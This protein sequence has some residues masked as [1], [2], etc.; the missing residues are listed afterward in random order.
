[1]QERKLAGVWPVMLTPFTEE[2]KVDYPALASLIEW[3]L[4]QG[5]A[6]MFAVCQSS[7]M[8][9]LS[10]EERV[11]I[12]R[13]VNE[14][15]N[16]RVPVI[17]SG[18]IS[19]SM[20][21]QV[22]E[23]LAVAETGVE[24]VI[25]ITN[26]LAKEEESDTIWLENLKKLLAQIP[27]EIHLGF[28]E[29]PY[30][31]KRV[32]SPEL[33]RFCVES[34]RFY[35]LKDTCCDI[36][37]IRAKLEVCKDSQLKLYNAN[38][39]TLL[40]S[41]RLG[42]AGYSGVMANMQCSLYVRMCEDFDNPSYDMERLSRQLTMC[43]LIERQYYPVNAKYYLQL[44]GVLPAFH[45]R[46][47][48]ASGLNETWKAEMR[49]LRE[50]T[51][52]LRKEYRTEE[53]EQVG[54]NEMP[55]YVDEQQPNCD[56][57]HGQ[58]FPAKGVKCRQIV[59]ANCHYPELADGTD[60]TYKHA[61]D[62]AYFAGRFYV[63][64][65]CNPKEEHT[66]AGY[67]VLAS[68]VDGEIWDKFQIS[69]PMYPIRKTTVTDYKGLTHTFDGSQFAF[70]HQR[71]GFFRSS[72]NRMLVLGFYGWSPEKWMTNWDNYGIGRVVREL[73]PDGSLSAIYFIRP[74][75]QGGWSKN[76][77]NYPLY[78]ESKDE[79]FVE[80]CEELLASPLVV[81]QWAEEN[82]D[83][84]SLIQIKHPKRGTY[85]AFCSY[86]I[87]ENEVVG[88]WKHSFVA[89]SHD[90]GKNWSQVQKSPSLVMSGQKIWG[91]KTSDGRFALAYDPTLETEH[92][93][94]L[95]VTTSRDGIHFSKMRLVHGQV[96][97]IRNNG[98]WKDLGP[99]YMR[100][101]AEGI[102]CEEN[103][104]QD[105]DMYLTYSVNKE[106][107]WFAQIPV[108][109]EDESQREWKEFPALPLHRRNW[110]EYTPKWVSVQSIQRQGIDFPILEVK[111]REPMDYSVLERVL[112]PAKHRIL[113]MSLIPQK[114]QEGIYLEL[115]DAKAAVAVRLVFRNNGILY[116]RTVTEL[117]VIPYECER[118]IKINLDVDCRNF[119]YT[120]EIN[121]TPIC[122]SEGNMVKWKF[123]QA[124]NETSRFSI[125]TGSRK[126]SITLETI[127]DRLS[128]VPKAM[129][130]PLEEETAYA[131]VQV[132]TK[133]I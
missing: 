47:K 15:V 131:L 13:F 73:Y 12:A 104:P 44:E 77:L 18:H 21:E 92:R 14:T 23:I 60:S 124:V 87:D 98:F 31:Y 3:Y 84:D 66:G 5:V 25:L 117:N 70:M 88:L 52:L 122:N 22:R 123:M 109:I 79:A 37:Q 129:S 127:P 111:D 102:L 27:E 81:Q 108:P 97:R 59:R 51:R 71:M 54:E 100:G 75:W 6:G 10:L 33:L 78:Q 32:L 9:Y 105:L 19:D 94:P 106:D 16:G 41:L 64:Y 20:E 24:A 112:V 1:M 121:D 11:S 65:L 8:F 53:I 4:E 113:E 46:T 76:D 110:N 115:M 45:S 91:Q 26:R 40:E 69:F 96:P 101:I 80:A 89:R 67:S 99:Q 61:P 36:E 63:Q 62:I 126:D 95:C 7:E 58:I 17:A 90:G 42:A 83:S 85:Q 28:Y 2:N 29:C 114:V 38:T 130:M 72:K 30:P 57:H 43:A 107:I 103:R 125:R 86:H 93:Y 35:F 34:G 132:A 68:S 116:A 133:E 48:D 39:A 50:E 118:E 56:Y 120:I 119:E 82:G 49:M 55:C 128:D 74:N